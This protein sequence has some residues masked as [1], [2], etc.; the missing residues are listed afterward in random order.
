MTEAMPPSTQYLLRAADPRAAQELRDAGLSGLAAEV[1]SRRGVTDVAAAKRFVQ[2]NLAE[3]PDPYLLADAEKAAY[4]LAQAIGAAESIWVYGDYDVDGITAAALLYTFLSDVGARVQVFLPDRMR[5]GYGLH[6][7]RLAELCDNGAQLIISV[8]C[9]A[10]AVAEIASVRDRGVD[11]IVVDHHALGEV[12]PNATALL[13]PRRLDCRY[14]D[15]TLAAVGVALVLAQATRRA[16]VATGQMA[17]DKALPM[18]ALLE[19]AGLGTM[20]DLVPLQ[21]V[22]RTFAY[23]GLRSLGQSQRAG[24]Q[25]LAARGKTDL[26]GLSAER[27]GFD[28]APRINATGRVSDARTAFALLTTQSPTEAAALA[29]RIEAD[30]DARKALQGDVSAAALAQAVGQTHAVVVQG[31]WHPGVVGIV[32][33]KVVEQTGLP[34]LVLAVGEDGLARGSGRSVGGYDLVEGLRAIC[35][36]GLTERLGGHAFACGLTIRTERIA[37]LQQRWAAHVAANLSAESRRVRRYVDLEL[38]LADATTDWLEDQDALEPFGKGFELPLLLLRDVEV[39]N[40]RAIGAQKDW[41]SGELLEPGRQA[42]W[43]RKSVRLFAAQALFAAV[44]NGDRVDAIVHLSR[45]VWRGVASVQARVQAV[46]PPGS[47][48]Q[49]ATTLA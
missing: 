26:A 10:T 13:N 31:P 28:L 6:K 19:F 8:D 16:L 29:E 30:N 24:V 20:A 44:H 39:Q 3:L 5:D 48:L 41:V 15:K 32:A 9:G 35:S 34:A 46:L 22:N 12:L 45:N 42:K 37:E 1:L 2:P 40:L 18:R 4:R 27:V 14:P 21:G 47:P 49:T 25:A 7:E 36:D 17:R 23:H 11:F 38:T 43:A 33:N